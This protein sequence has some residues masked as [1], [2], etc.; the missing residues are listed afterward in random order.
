M[1]EVNSGCDWLILQ[2]E[3][4][5]DKVLEREQRE[6]REPRT[7]NN[8]LEFASSGPICDSPG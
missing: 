2:H 3:N 1:L 4:R 5:Q 8:E 6:P 7:L